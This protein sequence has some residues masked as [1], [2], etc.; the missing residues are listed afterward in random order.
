MSQRNHY[1]RA[2]FNTS[3]NFALQQTN[4]ATDLLNP[5]SIKLQLCGCCQTMETGMEEAL[6]EAGRDLARLISWR[7][8]VTGTTEL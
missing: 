2:V 7:A 5:T 1:Q 4:I 3:C 8:G 6:M